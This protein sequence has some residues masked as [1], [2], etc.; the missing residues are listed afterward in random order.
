MR[1]YYRVIPTGWEMA[2]WKMEIGKG[3]YFGIR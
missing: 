3:G 2:I 1:N